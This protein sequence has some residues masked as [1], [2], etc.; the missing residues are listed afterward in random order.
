MKNITILA[1]TIVLGMSLTACGGGGDGGGDSDN[2]PVKPDVP[3]TP[4]TTK[5]DPV[6]IPATPDPIPDETPAEP[7][8]PDGEPVPENQPDPLP[9]S[10][11]DKTI[12]LQVNNKLSLKRS[13]CG[14][15]GV[16]YNENLTSI[17]QK[18]TQYLKYINTNIETASYNPHVQ[19]TLVGAEDVTGKSNPYFFGKTALDRIL[20]T[21]Y[22]AGR[23]GVFENIAS[24]QQISNNPLK[25]DVEETSTLMLNSLLAA[26]YHAKALLD[27]RMIESGAGFTTYT[28][29]GK[30][31]TRAQGNI[32]VLNGGTDGK[33][34]NNPKLRE[35]VLTYPC[36]NQ[37]GLAQA[38]YDESP[39]PFGN[40]RDLAVNPIGQ[41]IYVVDND[42][43]NIKV[44]NVKF[45]DTD[46]N[47]NVP[48]KVLDTASDPHAN[49][50]SA[51]QPNEA[52]IMPLTDSFK[53]CRGFRVGNCGLY[54]FT[55]HSVSFDL[56]VDG[57]LER[58]TVKFKTGKFSG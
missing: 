16:N 24:R 27:R 25:V 51:M 20:T 9:L 46:R 48:V 31:A 44:T 57:K 22:A 49:T 37:E 1:S 11:E 10:A 45:T 30:D 39:N 35:G 43:T 19:A 50:S 12:A 7:T 21:S 56:I 47:I 33:L 5:P 40:T 55:N 38:L 15:G 13:E 32:L 3:T 6:D 36:N 23:F 54:E 42:A 53:T 29:Y 58:R 28:P 2:T 17:A 8:K 26:P 18:H 41:P 52:F 4:D 14:F 34:A